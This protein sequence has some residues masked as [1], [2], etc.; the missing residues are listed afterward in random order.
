[1]MPQEK[2][3]TIKVLKKVS[4][5]FS[6]N[7]DAINLRQ[8]SDETIHR[9]SIFKEQ[10]AIVLAIITYALFKIKSDSTKVTTVQRDKIKLYLE[11]SISSLKE[12]NY[13]KYNT[14][15]KKLTS[16]IKKIDL[17]YS[18]NIGQLLIKS[19]IVKGAMMFKHGLSIGFI[20]DLLSISKWDLISYIGKTKFTEV[21]EN[22]DVQSRLRYL[23]NALKWVSK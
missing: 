3:H 19:K 5:L 14:N 23:E 12:S 6:S 15:L 13:S 4:D 11:N 1:M 22:I 8:L 2:T 18:N 16:L 10:D 7:T 21:K 17:K 9:A 20:A